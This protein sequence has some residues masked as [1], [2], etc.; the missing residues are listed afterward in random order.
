ME[1]KEQETSTLASTLLHC[2]LLKQPDWVG[3]YVTDLSSQ[4]PH[5]L[6]TDGMGEGRHVFLPS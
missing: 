3:G 4:L 2:G 5:E 1:W 6:E